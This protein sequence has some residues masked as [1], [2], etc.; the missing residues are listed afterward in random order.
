MKT[1]L[2]LLSVFFFLLCFSTYSQK[3]NA[4]F[5]VEIIKFYLT[6]PTL[7]TG[8]VHI[9]TPISGGFLKMGILF[10][11]KLE[12]ELDG[13]Y[14]LGDWFAGVET[15]FIAKYRFWDNIFPFIT[16]L[17]HQN[18]GHEGTG[19][20]TSNYTYNFFGAGAELK[21]SKLFS[22]ELAFYYPVG[23]RGFNYEFSG[24]EFRMVN[25]TKIGLLFR[26]GFI[27]SFF[28]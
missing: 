18:D 11:D 24:K 5:K 8:D 3:F 14:Q 23:E 4:G 12:F 22:A 20:G 7:S 28:N 13:G 6:E 1:K 25:T 17:N 16:Y 10:F 21:A 15:A 9:L 2:S 19:S 26:L 27:F